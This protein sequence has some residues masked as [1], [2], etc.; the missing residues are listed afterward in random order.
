M[1]KIFITGVSGLL[2][3]N[4]AKIYAADNEVFGSYLSHPCTIQGCQTFALDLVDEKAVMPMIA[5]INPDWIIHCAAMTNIDFCE[6]HRAEALA[7]NVTASEHVA[8]AAEQVNARLTHISTDAFFN[9]DKASYSEDDEPNPPN[10]YA[11]TKWLAEQAVQR[12]ASQ[13]QVIRTNIYG[14]NLQDKLSLAEWFWINLKKGNSIQGFQDVYVNS[15]LVNNLADVLKELIALDDV[16][17]IL[18]VGGGECFNKYDF[19]CR[20]ADVFG[21]DKSLIQP[22]ALAD[23]T[24]KAKRSLRMCLAIDK[25]NNLLIHNKPLAL[26]PSL[27]WFKDLEQSGYTTELK[28][29][30]LCA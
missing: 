8:R 5:E 14:W 22:V 17:G 3:S 25:I 6:S 20:L 26:Q 30:A 2:G 11:E 28:K 10:Y 4:L 27:E 16:S 18:H 19:G 21:F 24:L 12:C 29:G 1:R 15:I 13:A 23:S 7:A 9:G